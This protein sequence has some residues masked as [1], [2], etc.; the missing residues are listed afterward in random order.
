MS[1]AAP[2]RAGAPAPS[3]SGP[4]TGTRP[5][6][7]VSLRQDVR[8][9]APWVMGISALSASSILAYNWIF[10]S[11]ADR[12]QL[13]AALGGNPALSLVFGPARDLLTADGFNAWRA[14]Q[15][16][17]LL[18]G[19]MAILAVI[20]NSRANED[21]GQAE[22][23]ASGVMARASRLATAVLVASLASVAIGVV[24]FLLTVACG[25][26]VASTA[27]LAAGFTASGLMFAG[28]AAIAAQIGS[29][30]RT[31]SSLAMSALGSLYILRGYIDSSGGAD[32]L[33]WLTPFGWIENARA[34]SGN[35]PWPLAACAVLAV[36][37]VLLAFVLQR[38]RDFGQGLIAPRPGPARAGLA[39]NAWGLALK[40]NRA[41]LIAWLIAFAVLGALFGNLA[42]SVTDLLASNP[43]LADV[44]A[45][46]GQAAAFGFLVTILQ[47]LGI[48]AAIMGAQIVLRVHSEEIEY[49]VEPLLATALRRRTYLASNV[50][51][52]FAGP[53]LGLLVAG[54]GMGVVA[55]LQD[56]S[57]HVGDVLA[58]SAATVVG[59]WVLIA[60]AVAAVGAVPAARVVAWLGIVA[61]FAI[62]LLGPTFT[63]PSW[64]LGI[65]PLF[66]I[67]NVTDTAPDWAG[68]LWLA[69][70]IVLLTVV[71]FVGYRRRSIV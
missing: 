29:D 41:G 21:S 52:A 25:G 33:S 3:R 48:V 1:V 45:G 19:L 37:L 24:C 58:Q 30:A 67:P 54:T 6:L 50:A 65:S 4:L 59:T 16:G 9:L 60:L 15:L 38:R 2:P 32:W 51:I 35:N 46:G 56:S 31:A 18:A 11:A 53:A 43:G 47:I 27:I 14:G 44:L 5:L 39:G 64:A 34:G 10:P 63:L 49:R 55:H 36:A 20:R 8:S 26:G 40:L 62:T 69:L 66:H 13:A 17:A 68:L 22:L 12:A 23:L 70:V 7:L 28:G 61:T 71:G 57:V 42:S